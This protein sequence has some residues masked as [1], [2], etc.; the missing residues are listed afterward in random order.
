MAQT[1]S[2]KVLRNYGRPVEG[3]TTFY[4]DLSE[5]DPGFCQLWPPPPAGVNGIYRTV[6]LSIPGGDF[7]ESRVCGMCIDIISDGSGGGRE[8]DKVPPGERF[9]LYVNNANAGGSPGDLDMSDGGR[10]GKWQAT[11]MATDCD[12][13]DQGV[14]VVFESGSSE[15]YMGI[16]IVNG[17]IPF[18]HVLY[19][20]E[21]GQ[22]WVPMRWQTRH[23]WTL[24][25]DETGV[26]WPERLF[27]APYRFRV[28]SM[29]GEVKEITVDRMGSGRGDYVYANPVVQFEGIFPNR[30]ANW[31]D[32]VSCEIEASQRTPI[33]RDTTVVDQ[34]TERGCELLYG[35]WAAET[36]ANPKC[37]KPTELGPPEGEDP[38]TCDQAGRFFPRQACGDST[39]TESNCIMMGCCYDAEAAGGIKEFRD[40]IAGD[41]DGVDGGDGYEG[42]PACF[43]RPS[44]IR[45][46]MGKVG[47][48][49]TYAV[50]EG[51]H[52]RR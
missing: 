35:C 19:F 11:W 30:P 26:P 2:Q 40:N 9:R 12:P 51:M 8:G 48:N 43:T 46:Y 41:I 38:Y 6:A 32:T 4:W 5:G 44:D 39:T 24:S 52:L 36:D 10:D 13:G 34:L 27:K 23:M 29:K 50:V 1:S 45:N 16:Q 37:Y 20:S 15:N 14:A 7:H 3:L 28:T 17:P 47:G 25:A 31:R 49:V 18:R 21:G 33:V 22:K 42:P